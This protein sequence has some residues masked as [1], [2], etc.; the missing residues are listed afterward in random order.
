M[1]LRETLSNCW[2]HIQ[3]HLFPWLQDELGPLTD[4]HKGLIVVLDMAGIEAFVRMWSGLPAV[5]I[6]SAQTT[7]PLPLS[8]WAMRVPEVQATLSHHTS[9]GSDVVA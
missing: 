6:V 4:G 7:V 1:P 3:G 2:V 5:F 8:P 9:Q